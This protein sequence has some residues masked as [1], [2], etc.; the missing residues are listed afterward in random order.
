MLQRSLFLG[1]IFF[2]LTGCGKEGA[3]PQKPQLVLDRDSIGFGQEFGSG[4]FLGTQPQ[5]SL[6]IE[7]GGLENLTL[8]NVTLTG[9]GEFKLEGPTLNELK[10]KEHTFLRVL[11]APT[12]VKTYSAVITINSN[13]ENAPTKLVSVS[14]RGVKPSADGG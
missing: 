7:N 4:T 10:G 2:L 12:Q 5:E 14:G 8:A 1:F 13:A 9:D 6:L 3:L 11:F